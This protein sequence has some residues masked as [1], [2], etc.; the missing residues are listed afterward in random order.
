MEKFIRP[1]KPEWF[2]ENKPTSLFS[3]EEKYRVLE[4]LLKGSENHCA[5]TD[6]VS[7]LDSFAIIE[8]SPKKIHTKTNWNNLF[9]VINLIPAIIK[10]DYD[11]RAIRPDEDEYSF[12]KYFFID[13]ASGLLSPNPSLPKELQERAVVTI[14]IFSLNHPTLVNTRKDIAVLTKENID[15]VKLSS[16]NLWSFRFLTRKILADFADYQKTGYVQKATIQNFYCIQNITIEDLG[17]KKEVYFLGENGDGKT[18]LLQALVLL[19]ERNYLN[20]NAEQSEV[21]D[22]LDMLKDLVASAVDYSNK[23]EEGEIGKGWL[24]NVFAYGISRNQTV[25]E[26]DKYGFLTLFDKRKKLENPTDWLLKLK[27][28]QDEK[29]YLGIRTE[30]AI[31]LLEHL[32]DNN[33]KIN[34]KGSKVS[35]VER[36][37]EISFD[38]LSE[39]Y[40]SVLIWVTDLV[41]R[42]SERRPNFQTIKNE[43]N[44]LGYD[45][46]AVV[47]VDEINL[48]LHPKWEYQ[49]VRKLRKWFPNIQFFFTTHSPMTVMGAS[50]DA[51]FYRLYKENGVTQISEPYFAKDMDNWLANVLITSPLFDME[52]A[53]MAFFNEK[54]EADTATDNLASQIRKTIKE[55]VLRMKKEDNKTYASRETI[56]NMINKAIEKAKPKP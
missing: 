48:H 41:A 24:K 33:L 52:S 47:L 5:Y 54:K 35:F 21:A 31:D 16:I 32:T 30:Q 13:Y 27:L 11:A 6:M 29:N 49:I 53:R 4:E 20:K 34:I 56:Q 25:G 19:F 45:F 17:G 55:E 44:S 2:D 18:L 40:R 14:N 9:P 38:K 1:P 8:I 39:G 3:D 15:I 50:D 46:Q 10:A 23:E 12:D 7:S 26:A 43:D 51:V 42:L 37:F 28:E 36:G 22:T